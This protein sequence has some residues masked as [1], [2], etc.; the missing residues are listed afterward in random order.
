MRLDHLSEL[1]DALPDATLLVDKSGTIAY[2]NDRS[3]DLLGYPQEELIGLGIEALVPREFRERHA[4]HQVQYRARP[5]VSEMGG[6][7]EVWA[8]R[9]DGRKIPVDISLGPVSTSSGQ[10]VMASIRDITALLR[11][12]SKLQESVELNRAVLASLGDHIAVLG[13]DGKI[14]LVNDAWERF[15]RQEDVGTLKSLSVGANY[16]RACSRAAE[17]GES[18]A[19]QAFIA[20][21][22]VLDGTKEM[23]EFEYP[24]PTPEGIRWFI[25]TILPVRRGQCGVVVCHTDV[26]ELKT[27]ELRLRDTL[28][29]VN[30]LKDAFRE[31]NIYLRGELASAHEFDEIIGES[32]PLREVLALVGRVAGTDS[33]VLLL[34]ETGTGKEL[35]A[36]AIHER[37]HRA[38]GP[39]IRV[40]CA[41]LPSGLI[42][43]ELFGHV[44][45]AFTGALQDKAGRFELAHGG[46]LFLDEIGEIDPDLQT[47]L[48]RVLQ[49]REFERIGSSETIKANVRIITATNQDLERAVEA[50]NFRADLFFRLNVFPIQIPPLRARRDDIPAL[51]R[52]F[53]VKKSV[54]LRKTVDS[55]SNQAM[56]AALR[57]DWPGNVRELENIVER[58]MI[59][60][61]GP[62]LQLEAALLPSR[63]TESSNRQRDN[64]VESLEQIGRAHIIR[65]LE[66]C[67][68]KI[69]GPDNAAERLGMAPSTLRYRMKK[70]GIHVPR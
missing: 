20:I 36:R 29:E 61:S 15:S 64:S 41:A 47:K 52:H 39:L 54:E 24:S 43:S 56:N 44:K 19:Q 7:R 9:K 25:A 58:S 55:I 28:E 32:Q 69:K 38:D 35:F 6:R 10:F 2:A 67:D 60:S 45:G 18:S 5:V 46:T 62:R 37:S 42:E 12:R 11:I 48:L 33:T 4:E 50:G 34:G 17:E 3:G 21:T 13:T 66:D 31:E 16:L 49:E 51:I 14:V 59:V 63:S 68:W 65:V 27:T 26:T 30:R 40:N 70:L 23:A 22:S 53:V 8:V 57:Y 1:L